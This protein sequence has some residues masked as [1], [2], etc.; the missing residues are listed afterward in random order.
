MDLSKIFQEN[1][2]QYLQ[3][4]GRNIPFNHL[5]AINAIINCRTSAM[6][7]EVYFCEECKTYHYSYHSCQNRHCPKCQSSRSSEW[8]ER[9]LQKL[10]PVKYHLVGFTIP[11]ELH[12]VFR[13]N[14]KLCY[15]LLFKSAAEALQVLLADPKYAGG[16]GGII[17]VLHTWTRT[18]LYHPHVHFIVPGGAYDAL[19]HEWRDSQHAFLIPVL[20]LSI[21][22]RAKLRDNLKTSNPKLFYSIPQQVWKREFVTHSKPAGKGEKALKY[23]SNYVYRIAITNNRI[24]RCEN[25]MV[26]FQYKESKTNKIK[27][28]TVSALEFMR[29]FLQHV[30]PTGFQKVRYYGF[31]SSAAKELFKDVKQVLGTPKQKAGSKATSSKQSERAAN[32]C[33][34]CSKIMKLVTIC[35]RKKRAPPFSWCIEKNVL[36]TVWQRSLA[37][38]QNLIA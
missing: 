16:I 14:Q 19:R 30:L 36:S 27:F 17:G 6:G 3:L 33:P 29:R 24:V 12:K 20:A 13:S 7:G 25:G 38:K 35:Y 10:L 22:Y 31:M 18:L 9:Q 8:L 5:K 15:S 37:Q 28:Q 34:D 2:S 1:I 4:Y 23:L 26:T 32:V 11:P 21:L